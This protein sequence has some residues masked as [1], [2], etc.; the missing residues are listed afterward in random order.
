MCETQ[1][2]LKIDCI[3]AIGLIRVDLTWLGRLLEK[4][5]EPINIQYEIIWTVV[6]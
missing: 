1:M 3:E 5:I 2:H 6:W 4:A